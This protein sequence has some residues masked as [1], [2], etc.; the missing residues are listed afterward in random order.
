LK[1][2]W[3]KRVTRTPYEHLEAFFKDFE[4]DN[5]F[6]E[7]FL[8]TKGREHAL[9]ELMQQPQQTPL[10]VKFRHLCITKEREEAERAEAEKAK[11]AEANEQD[12]EWTE[13]VHEDF[14]DFLQG[15]LSRRLSGNG[16]EF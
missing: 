4:V 8:K 10:A 16:A 9:Y 15:I 3:E 14:E 7:A 2:V 5:D 6:E 13:E 1:Q 11:E 12:L